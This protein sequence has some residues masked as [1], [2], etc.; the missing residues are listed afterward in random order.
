MTLPASVPR[1]RNHQH[2]TPTPT[3]TLTPTLELCTTW[4]HSIKPDQ[5]ASVSKKNLK[6]T[7][8]HEQDRRMANNRRF[9]FINHHLGK[10]LLTLGYLSKKDIWT[11]IL[12]N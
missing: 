12:R 3:P 8:R 9:Y 5:D 2:S 1:G 6:V 10:S 11:R 7:R 4:K